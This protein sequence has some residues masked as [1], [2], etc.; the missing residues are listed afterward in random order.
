MSDVPLPAG[1]SGGA[2]SRG[3]RRQAL[4]D[5]P[6]LTAHRRPH[7]DA[8]LRR[9]ARQPG[10][11]LI[12]LVLVVP[13]AVLLSVGAGGAEASVLVL[14]PLITFALPVAAMVAFWWED[15]PGSSLRPGWSG[16]AD[17]L[18]IA[19]AGILLTM[20][21]QVVVDRLDLRGIFDATPGPGHVAT[22][23]GTMSIA[24]A[25]FVAML[26]ITFAW[27]GWPL[28]RLGRLTAGGAALAASWAVALVLYFAV[29]RGGLLTGAE[30]GAFLVLA[31]LW[32]VWFYVVWRGWPFAGLRRRWLRIV[33]ANAVIVGGAGLTY[34]AAHL[35]G[36]VRPDTITA[37]AGQFIA[38]GLVVGILFEGWLQT[39]LPPAA[40][41][42]VALAAVL[43]LGAALSLALAAYADTV[44]W[45]K[46]T[47]E[48]WIGHVGLNA[49]GVSVILHVAI[50]RRWP[51]ASGTP[52][53]APAEAAT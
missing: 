36:G 46:A 41:R 8:E 6:L 37:A 51:F 28:R 30:F 23:P 53:A 32:Q 48:D 29:D 52:D 33:S 50:G 14:G 44:T 15:W 11:G 43:L 12:G 31:G 26:Q 3:A 19:F 24:G 18:V 49:I 9:H 17:T 21:G 2:S 39:R 34:A 38:V 42:I 4:P 13:V 35:V 1:R 40:E 20:L 45:T 16:L 27:E 22:F 10:L 47:G 5:R 7:L 25:A